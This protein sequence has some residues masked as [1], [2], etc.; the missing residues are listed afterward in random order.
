MKGTHTEYICMLIIERNQSVHRLS[1]TIFQS[2][3]LSVSHQIV[4]QMP[5]VYLERLFTVATLPGP[6]H[7]GQQD[8]GSLF[9]EFWHCFATRSRD[10]VSTSET[11]RHKSDFA[12][13]QRESRFGQ[14]ASSLLQKIP[15]ILSRLSPFSNFDSDLSRNSDFNWLCACSSCY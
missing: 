10:L 13:P 6:F 8:I 3:C 4:C 5:W 2:V 11:S 7:C 15:G 1:V 9:I 14:P 12:Q